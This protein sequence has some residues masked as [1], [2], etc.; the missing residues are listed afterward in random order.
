MAALAKACGALPLPPPP[1]P[2][3]SRPR[4]CVLPPLLLLLLAAAVHRAAGAAGGWGPGELQRERS[5]AERHLSFPSTTLLASRLTSAETHK[6]FTF[7][8]PCIGSD[9]A[10][11][12][13]AAL[14]PQHYRGE[15]QQ[16]DPACFPPGSEYSA[17][18]CCDTRKG[19]QGDERCWTDGFNHTRCCPH[20]DIGGSDSGNPKDRW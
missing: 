12:A 5:I 18:R 15:L 7:S 3:P 13:R 4:G 2:P 10:L 1:P 14:L 11:L 19:A 20:A 16:L 6:R 8:V 17:A 9:A